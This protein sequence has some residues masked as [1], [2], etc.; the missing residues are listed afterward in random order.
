MEIF[1][2]QQ[3]ASWFQ[4]LGKTKIFPKIGI[5][6]DKYDILTV[7]EKHIAHRGNNINR[8]LEMNPR[9]REI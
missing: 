3:P 2:K 7:Q 8:S 1:L 9:Q 4:K 6:S 5:I